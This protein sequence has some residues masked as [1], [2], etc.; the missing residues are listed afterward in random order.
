QTTRFAPLETFADSVSQGRA[1]QN[2]CRE[3]RDAGYEPDIIIGH[4]GW[5]D[6]MFLDLVWPQAR[7]VSYMEFYYR[8]DARDAHFDP[9]FKPRPAE[10]EFAALRNLNQLLAFERSAV[11]ITPTLWQKQLFPDALTPAMHVI[12][13]GVDT[14]A[15]TPDPAAT[16]RLPD[17]RTLDRTTPVLTYSA[18]NLEPYR[19]FHWFMRA[20]P[21]IQADRPDVFTIIVGGEDVSYGRRPELHANWKQALLDEVGDQ[22]DLSRIWF[23][24]RLAYDQ[25]VSVLQLSWV[26]MYLS[27][28]FVLS[29]S[30]IEAMACGCAIVA[31]RTEPVQE[32]LA[33]TEN[34]MLVDFANP[35]AI[36]DA[37]TGLLADA[38][39]RQRLGA[40]ARI[41]AETRYDV[42]RMALPGYERL[43]AGLLGI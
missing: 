25:Y 23:A 20:L 5:G 42:E 27:Y 40:A 38:D 8:H 33:D 37:V 29:W 28:P 26:H 19:G 9:E 21:Q 7:Q 11:C 4:P 2:H 14:A 43:I 10:R 41:T 12:H 17:G 18:R 15:L 32:A 39:A 35:R 1:V 3:L 34:A 24:G 36:P 6:M 13:E 31:S 30:L 22:L 16:I